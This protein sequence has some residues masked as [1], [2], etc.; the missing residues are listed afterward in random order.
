MLLLF[1]CSFQAPT[2]DRLGDKP[3]GKGGSSSLSQDLFL[4]H[5]QPDYAKSYIL[6]R[7]MQRDPIQARRLRRQQAPAKSSG[8][9]KSRDTFKFSMLKTTLDYESRM[10]QSQLQTSPPSIMQRLPSLDKGALANV[11]LGPFNSASVHSLIQK[12]KR[13]R[14][15]GSSMASS[16][17]G[18]ATVTSGGGGSS[19]GVYN[20]N[21]SSSSNYCKGPGSLK[22]YIDYVQADGF[23]PFP[24]L[25]P[26]KGVEF[27]LY[28]DEPSSQGI[29]EDSP[30]G[31]ESSFNSRSSSRV[32]WRSLSNYHGDIT[33]QFENIQSLAEESQKE[34]AKFKKTLPP[35]K[36]LSTQYEEMESLDFDFD[37]KP[38]K[39]PLTSPV[40]KRPDPRGSNP[41]PPAGKRKG[42]LRKE[43]EEED[44]D[45][46]GGGNS[47][48]LLED[49]GT[50][51]GGASSLFLLP[52]P[53]KDGVSGG[54]SDLLDF[55]KD[56]QATTTTDGLSA[57]GDGESF[58]DLFI[59]R[60][61]VFGSE[62][63]PA[64]P[65][66]AQK[67]DSNKQERGRSGQNNEFIKVSSK[68]QP[69][70]D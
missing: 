13:Y 52:S 45:P 21:N 39:P 3:D 44:D 15:R 14:S 10:P 65:S 58:L 7:V 11:P 67:L 68:S 38:K 28:A 42:L 18:A 36:R 8:K 12:R 23:V 4:S 34:S 20:N 61:S 27:A 26:E 31:A 49:R 47:K 69:V 63:H 35:K 37:P 6:P 17:S 50:K 29:N 62:R 54:S 70:K 9:S 55:T 19:G 1:F 5:E 41:S 32:S 25:E 46:L 40:K 56:D 53:F 66:V 57:T 48:P 30:G 16:V 51:N 2:S 24:V 64:L 43:S 22:S 33:S 59:D 60:T